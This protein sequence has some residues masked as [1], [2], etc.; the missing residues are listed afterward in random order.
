MADTADSLQATGGLPTAS[1]SLYT[2]IEGENAAEQNKSVERIF[3]FLRNILNLSVVGT[4]L[5]AGPSYLKLVAVL[6][7][8]SPAV[9]SWV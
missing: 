9:E 4:G 5:T 6:S 8:V 2:K 1:S 3:Y 7:L